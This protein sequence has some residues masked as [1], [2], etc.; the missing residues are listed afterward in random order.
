MAR[1]FAKDFYH[2]KA[3]HDCRTAY[4]ASRRWLCE[5]CYKQ[6]KLTPGTVVHHII[7]LSPDNIT[8]PA[9]TLGW[10]NLELVCQD[11]HAKLHRLGEKRFYCDE[12]GRVSPLF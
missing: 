1:D 10:S 8:D 6:N 3:W 12:E 2:S 5:E 9:I 4:G 11:C 7:H